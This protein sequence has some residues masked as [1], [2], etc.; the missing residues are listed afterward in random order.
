LIGL[1]NLELH[2]YSEEEYD[3]PKKLKHSI[4][5]E[6]VRKGIVIWEG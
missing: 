2:V 6:A 5:G 1:P 3:K 4:I